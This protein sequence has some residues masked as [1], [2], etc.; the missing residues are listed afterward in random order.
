MLNI[1]RKTWQLCYLNNLD[2]RLSNVCCGTLRVVA[3]GH[4]SIEEFTALA[5]LHDEVNRLAV[6][7]GLSQAHDVGVLRQGLHDLHLPPHVDHVL[8]APDLPLGDDL[9]RQGFAG[10]VVGAA[11][12]HAELAPPQLGPQAV[13]LQEVDGRKAVEDGER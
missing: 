8:H 9:A 4:D 3:L 1:A 10:L 6:L 2:D 5:D 11:P 7:V 13:T 12:G